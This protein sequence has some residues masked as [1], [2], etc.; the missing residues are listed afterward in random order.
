[1]TMNILGSSPVRVGRARRLRAVAEAVKNVVFTAR[2]SK[3]GAKW[4]LREPRLKDLAMKFT[5]HGHIF[6]LMNQ[7]F[8][9]QNAVLGGAPGRLD[10]F[11]I[12]SNSAARF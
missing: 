8:E 2:L 10:M 1:M 12:F 6:H 9:R 11:S 5:I 4:R 7:I 3:K